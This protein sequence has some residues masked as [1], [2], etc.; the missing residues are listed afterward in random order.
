M[1]ELIPAQPTT[2]LD[3]LIRPRLILEC[4]VKWYKDTM[5]LDP[6][7]NRHME[8]Y[9]NRHVLTLKSVKE[10]DFGNYSCMAD[11]SLGRERGSIEVSGRPH[12]AKILS[13]NLGFKKDQYN[14]T[15]TV[16]SFLPIEEYRIL[17]RVNLPPYH[18]I[19]KNRPGR[20]AKNQRDSNKSPRF[21]DSQPSEWTNIIPQIPNT[22]NKSPYDYQI[23]GNSFSY[24]GN[25]VFFGLTPSTEYEVIIQSRNREGWSDATD[26]FR[27]NT[28]SQ[29]F[30]PLEQPYQHQ[31]Y[32]SGSD[33]PKVSCI[34][35]IIA[36][37]WL[38]LLL[39]KF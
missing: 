2:T 22:S 1:L 10:T 18:A 31:G 38:T 17:Y 13:S 33:T 23:I 24:T 14:L 39:V 26:I 28:R 12:R 7:N 15:W 29:D 16:D 27:F 8:V 35:T 6:T 9:G 36:I 30:N 20:V 5:L 19:E 25:F 37:L 3:N 34:T 11:N 32:F 4:Y 21:L